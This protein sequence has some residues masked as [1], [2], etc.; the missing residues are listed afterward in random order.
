ML[1]CTLPFSRATF[2]LKSKDKTIIPF[3]KHITGFLPE[4][5]VTQPMPQTKL[6]AAVSGFLNKHR[7]AEGNVQGTVRIV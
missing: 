4:T 2:Q 5:A 6:D 3:Y 1:Y 7:K